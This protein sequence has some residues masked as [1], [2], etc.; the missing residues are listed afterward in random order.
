MPFAQT[1]NLPWLLVASVPVSR[2]NGEAAAGPGR[3]FQ[4]LDLKHRAAALLFRGAA[5]G[6]QWLGHGNSQPQTVAAASKRTYAGRRYSSRQRHRQ[7]EPHIA[8]LH[9]Q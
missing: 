9:L 4:Q 8:R 1:S 7:H 6:P 3:Q 5:G 2:T